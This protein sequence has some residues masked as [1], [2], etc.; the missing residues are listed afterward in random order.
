MGSRSVYFTMWRCLSHTHTHTARF[1]VFFFNSCVIV[2]GSVAPHCVPPATNKLSKCTAE[3]DEWPRCVRASNDATRQ[4]WR[5]IKSF[6]VTRF[7]T[8]NATLSASIQSVNQLSGVYAIVANNESRFHLPQT[9]SIDFM[10]CQGKKQKLFAIWSSSSSLLASCVKRMCLASKTVGGL[11]WF[12]D[13][14]NGWKLLD[15]FLSRFENCI[16][17]SILNVRH[18][19]MA[20]HCLPSCIFHF[21]H[22]FSVRP[23]IHV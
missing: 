20:R 17:L 6:L 13:D 2:V 16:Y 14:A 11:F 7:S 9:D 10:A 4:K 1:L 8:S 15:N 21:A 18:L 22:A 12:D 23:P 5:I 19:S 3:C